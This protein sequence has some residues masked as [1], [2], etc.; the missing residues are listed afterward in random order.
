MT[1]EQEPGQLAGQGPEQSPEQKQKPWFSGFVLQGELAG[2]YEVE[3]GREADPQASPAAGA[4]EANPELVLEGL[5][6]ITILVG[7]NN[8]G[9]SRLLRGIFGDPSFVYFLQHG[10]GLDA[11]IR[12]DTFAR[13]LDDAT[14]LQRK[15]TGVSRNLDGLSDLPKTIREQSGWIRVDALEILDHVGNDFRKWIDS[16]DRRLKRDPEVAQVRRGDLGA[17]ES[18]KRKRK[19]MQDV[20]EWI[21]RYRTLRETY[22]HLEK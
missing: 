11:S 22:G 21:S 19:A 16:A 7:A 20:R 8:S 1:D 9:K 10:D 2:L 4:G 17:M 14:E 15:W 13:L 6:P 5:A 12:P 18:S 3:V